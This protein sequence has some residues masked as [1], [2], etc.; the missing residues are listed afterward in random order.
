[1]AID[2]DAVLAGAVAFE[3]LQPIA[4][5]HP[6]ILQDA[7]LIEETQ[8]AQRRRPNIRRKHAGSPA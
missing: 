4:G 6:Q 2:A 8:L 3:R 5:R 1:M 7:G